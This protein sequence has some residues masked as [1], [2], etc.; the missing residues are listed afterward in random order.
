LGNTTHGAYRK[1]A[2]PPMTSDPH[3]C[4][5]A[6]HL[7]KHGL[8]QLCSLRAA[9]E[10]CALTTPM[11]LQIYHLHKA[12]DI[13]LIQPP[14]EMHLLKAQMVILKGFTSPAA[15]MGQA[16]H[17]PSRSHTTAVLTGATGAECL[18]G[19]L[20]APGNWASFSALLRED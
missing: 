4:G 11:S 9:E 2:V 14:S 19:S 7:K 3:A 1:A 17:T 6:T 5:K 10:H 12:K 20:R 18:K 8:G 15:T 13:W 16:Q